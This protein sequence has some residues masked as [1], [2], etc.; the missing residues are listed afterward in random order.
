[1]N[2]EIR[3]KK[4]LSSDQKNTLAGIM[5]IPDGDIRGIFHLVHGMTEY[6]GRYK[7]LFES[8][9][10]AGIVSGKGN[11]KFCPQDFVK[12]EEFVK[13]LV[14]AF[15]VTAEG[16][17]PFSDVSSNEWYYTYVV[18]AYNSG[19]IKGISA[20]IFGTGTNITR[21]DMAV[22]IYRY[23]SKD[24]ELQVPEPLNLP[25][26]LKFPNMQEKQLQL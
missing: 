13:M 11:K 16:S 6:I 23:L 18:S 5:Y 17:V 20:D 4:I 3:D 19:M 2:F 1:M 7:A 8:L 25:T 12:R 21:Q 10:N 22:L 9:A 24:T 26:R 14:G 15:N